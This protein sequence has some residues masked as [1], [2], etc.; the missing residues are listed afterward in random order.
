M[1]CSGHISTPDGSHVVRYELFYTTG[2]LGR[3]NRLFKDDTEH[4][5]RLELLFRR[6]AAANLKLKP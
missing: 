2:I 3:H 5:E 6:L 4:L 1:Q